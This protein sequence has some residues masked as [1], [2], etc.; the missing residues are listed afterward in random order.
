MSHP[1]F[2]KIALLATVF[3]WL[4]FVAAPAIL[5]CSWLGVSGGVIAVAATIAMILTLAL[6]VAFV[7]VQ[8][9]QGGRTPVAIRTMGPDAW[10]TILVL[11]AVPGAL[12]HNLAAVAIPPMQLILP[13]Y[14]T[15]LFNIVLLLAVRE[16]Q[17]RRSAS[18]R[19]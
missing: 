9:C 12:W 13:G 3:G 6:Q 10:F 11:T 14:V 19:A 5:L 1:V 16:L 18:A 8:A 17:Q 2:R 7:A 15:P 4:N